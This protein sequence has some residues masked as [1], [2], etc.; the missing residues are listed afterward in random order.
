M[1]N[2][3]FQRLTEAFGARIERWPTAERKAGVELARMS[4]KVAAMLETARVIDDALDLATPRID[5][6]AVERL[7]ARVSV[8]IDEASRIPPAPM[9]IWARVRPHA[10]TAG[11]LTAMLLAGMIVGNVGWASSANAVAV[12]LDGILTSGYNQST[13]LAALSE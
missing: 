7:L 10:P 13:Y 8:R 9:S 4:P 5:D 1:R 3:R 11:F 12:S 6:A 2:A